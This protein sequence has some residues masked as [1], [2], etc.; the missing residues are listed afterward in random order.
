MPGKDMESKTVTVTEP[1]KS[2]EVS[3]SLVAQ[4]GEIVISALVI[5]SGSGRTNT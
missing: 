1:V 3:L 2:L 5:Q 4:Q